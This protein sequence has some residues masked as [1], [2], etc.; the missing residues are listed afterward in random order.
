MVSRR[1]LVNRS[2]RWMGHHAREAAKQPLSVQ[3]SPP[4]QEALRAR[5]Q[6]ERGEQ[7]TQRGTD[8]SRQRENCEEDQRFG[9][10]EDTWRII[11]YLG[12]APLHRRADREKHGDIDVL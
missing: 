6:F 10:L 11:D 5:H 7:V 9:T 12:A 2:R 8:R 1:E 4:K 3:H